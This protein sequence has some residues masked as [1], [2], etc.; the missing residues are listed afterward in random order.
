MLA[1]KLAQGRVLSIF[2]FCNFMGYGYSFAAAE[3]VDEH[4]DYV[5]DPALFRNQSSQHIALVEKITQ[6]KS[7]L[8]GLYKVNL[9]VNGTF[10]RR[11]EL[12]FNEHTRQKVEACF[13]A[14]VW[15]Q[16]GLAEKY[17]T[18]KVFQASSQCAYLSDLIET[19]HSHFDFNKMRLDLSIPQSE[20][21]NLP[22]GYVNPADLE[23][24]NSIGFVNYT[25]NY[26][27]SA[28]DN[29]HQTMNQSAAFVALDGGV[30]FG[31]WQYRQQSNLSYNQERGTQWTNLRSAVSRPIESI[32]GV[33]HFGQLY[34]TGQFFSGLSFNG[35]NL[36]FDERML[37]DSMRGYAPIIQGV[38]QSNAKVSVYQNNREIYQTNVAPGSFK[39]SDLYPTNYSG[40]LTVKVQE[41]DGTT[42][43]FNVPFSAVPE[44]L[45]AGAQR[46]DFN[47]GQTRDL[48]E[49]IYFSDFSYQRGLSN[50][51]TVNTGL[52]IAEDYQALLLGSTY[53]S[54]IGAFGSNLTYSNAEVGEQGRLQGW[55]ANLT[56]S[57]TIQPTNTTISLAGYRYSTQG[58]RDLGDVI[59]VR[60]AEKNQQAWSSYTYKQRSR[61]EVT[62]N[63]SLAQYGTLFA[64]GAVQSYR[65]GRDNDIQAQIGYNKFFPNGIN[66]NMSLIRQY[67]DYK[68]AYS[69][70]S[71]PNDSS[72]N[73]P[74]A[75]VEKQSNTD[76]SLN[77]S[78]SFPLGRS[79][80]RPAQNIDFSYSRRNNSEDYYQ[81]SLSGTVGKDQKLNY[82]LGVGH[83]QSMKSTVW[84]A[85]L[86]KRL[87]SVTL[88]ANASTA[89]DFWQVSGNIQ[90]ALAVHS[91]GVT[92]G[93]YLSDT[94]A[95]IEA[96]GAEGARLFNGQAT[97]INRQGYALL[98]SISPYRYNTLSLDPTG[99]SER[100]EIETQELRVAP[101][102]GSTPKL[103]FKTRIG[104]PMLIQAKFENG[105]YLP[106]GADVIDT[107]G[108]TIAMVGQNGQIFI[109]AEATA[110]RLQVVWG[111]QTQQQCQIAYKLSTQ[112]L[113]Q[114][115]IRLEKNCMAEK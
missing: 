51:V 113:E 84:N 32:H 105:E 80:K 46:Y 27:H 43:Q 16:L 75:N 44:S 25:A 67:Y 10:I 54:S 76:T 101:Y 23:S 90:G 99:I 34:S 49:D 77:I 115:L 7:V 60:A 111:E 92:F 39:I 95:L 57:K 82:T 71:Y 12:A 98:A 64:S 58:Y 29:N 103:V 74:V 68:N 73:Q 14:D 36:S 104:Y 59:G 88:A 87:D 55:M 11:M 48:G 62:L 70:Q 37:P 53:I 4:D 89:K 24:G 2:L 38:A 106:L 8:P 6:Q 83:D 9:Y 52:R 69:G 65:D 108:Q 102:A 78:L 45:R 1:F 63:Q 19:S 56:Y 3:S 30:N 66:L 35:L 22:R 79:K 17:R 86:N 42:T 33:A 110:G 5:F 81:T 72:L 40:N 47:L 107:S 13:T 61:F 18:E 31:K 109:R 26:Y 41:A 28:V 97:R 91:G 100:V 50:S 15:G 20:M 96:K 112:D 94:F 93:P 21:L 85:S 114:S